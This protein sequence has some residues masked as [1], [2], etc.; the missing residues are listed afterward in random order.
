MAELAAVADQAEAAGNLDCLYKALYS[1]AAGYLA[2]NDLERHLAC[3][4]KGIDNC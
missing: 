2:R 3:R 1:L 4:Q